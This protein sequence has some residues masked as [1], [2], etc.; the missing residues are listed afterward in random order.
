MDG[1]S[2]RDESPGGFHLQERSLRVLLRGDANLFEG[3]SSEEG[4]TS[5]VLLARPVQCGL[6]HPQVPPN[7]VGSD[8]TTLH[9]PAASPH[10]IVVNSIRRQLAHQLAAPEELLEIATRLQN[11][12]Q[13]A[14]SLQRP[15][16]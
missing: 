2:H 6:K 14:L 15:I 7:R 9:A 16:R 8:P 5:F 12:L 10:H 13:I 11:V 3:V 4:V 1:W